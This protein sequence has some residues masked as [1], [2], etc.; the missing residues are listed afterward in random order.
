[1]KETFKPLAMRPDTEQYLHRVNSILEEFA[2]DGY[3]LTLRQLYYQLVG[4]D[5]IANSTSSYNKL[6]R[7]IASGRLAGLIDWEHIEDR[8]RVV[9]KTT[10]WDSPK[11]ILEAAA[12]QFKYDRLQGQQNYLEVWV[13]KDALSQ[14]VERAAQPYQVPVMVNRGYGS[15]S[16]MYE[17]Y[18]RFE[19]EMGQGKERCFI[20][21]LGDH[22]PSGL[23][24]VRDI[25]DRVG[26]MLDS[27]EYSAGS[28]DRLQVVHIALTM[29]QIKRYSPPPNPAKIT[30]SR[31]G[32]YIKRHGMKSWEVDALPP[33]TLVKLITEHLEQHL[34]VELYN[35][36][37]AKE[38]AVRGRALDY[39]NDFEDE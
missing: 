29:E 4:R 24:M 23:D 27:G 28:S 25:E 33:K 22:D 15:V 14:V 7:V 38:E 1:M 16:A 8:L 9:S 36:I 3:T 2:A 32:E 35:S 11:Q 31:A 13:E 12:R 20:L 26:G 37:K 21:Y 18:R 39:I 34:D 5:E 19:R 30:D 10:T 6:G 17:A